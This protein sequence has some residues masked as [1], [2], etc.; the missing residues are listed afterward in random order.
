MKGDKIFIKFPEFKVN[1][2]EQVELRVT[3]GYD[4]S[5]SKE[6]ICGYGDPDIWR[7]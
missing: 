4:G 5:E 1:N 3:V 7:Q 6:L 2:Y